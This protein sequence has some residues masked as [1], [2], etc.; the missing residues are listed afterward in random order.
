MVV[1]DGKTTHYPGIFNTFDTGTGETVFY[2]DK[3]PNGASPTDGG[4]LPV[5]S[6]VRATFA[7]ALPS[8]EALTWSFTVGTTPS[9]NTASYTIIEDPSTYGKPLPNVIPGLNLYN[10]FDVLFDAQKQL[11]YLRP[12]GGQA[13]VHLQSVNT[14]GAQS[15][16]QGFV[17]LN[18][19][20]TT[21]G[22]AFSVAGTTTLNADTTVKA[23]AGAVRFSGTVDGAVDGADALV[24]DT[25]GATTFV[26][27]I[28]FSHPLSS[29][30]V[31]GAGSTATAAVFT[32]GDQT[33]GGAVA[34]N[35]PYWVTQTSGQFTIA[36]ATT[37]EGPTSV[38]TCGSKS[39]PNGNDTVDCGGRGISVNFDGRVD[40][41]QGKGFPLTVA[42]GNA[43]TVSFDGAVGGTN[44]LGGLAIQSAQTVRASGTVTLDGSLGY[45]SAVGLQ[46]GQTDY[47][48]IVRTANFAAGGS[49][50]G[51]NASG[52]IPNGACSFSSNGGLFAACGSGVVVTG[53]PTGLIQDFTIASNAG[54]GIYAAEQ[55]LS[56]TISNARYFGNA[57]GDVGP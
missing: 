20:Y 9:V 33:Y 48:S 12:N 25:T 18:G 52:G 27:Q 16:Q 5:G 37:L 19:T 31:T 35:G 54:Y 57:L 10:D 34:L 22:G 32:T 21:G 43:G 38:N 14:T 4:N 47:S 8:G 6:E 23:G 13:T 53:T 45:S 55:P 56:L 11:I 39:G 15:Y 36:G 26:R 30:S 17:D 7:N 40:S 51:F 2:V 24:V 1:I 28:G 49:I 42:A 44:P 46:I 50:V 3:R 41:S 29:L